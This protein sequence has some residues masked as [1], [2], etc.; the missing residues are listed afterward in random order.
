M[1]FLPALGGRERLL[2]SEFRCREWP[3]DSRIPT[4]RN[5]GERTMNVTSNRVQP[6][7]LAELGAPGRSAA[8]SSSSARGDALTSSVGGL[9]AKASAQARSWS[10]CALAALALGGCSDPTGFNPTGGAGSNMDQVMAEVPEDCPAS[11][12]WLPAD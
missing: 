11:A 3:E 1:L 10:V 2:S 6:A 4:T 5:R 9:V 8:V 12:E 7:C